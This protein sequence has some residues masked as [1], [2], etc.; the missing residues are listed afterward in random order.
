MKT[1]IHK[2]F[3]LFL[4]VLLTLLVTACSPN[5]DEGQETSITP[6][7]QGDND[8]Q[9]DDDDGNEQGSIEFSGEISSINGTVIV[10][11]G[12][13]VETASASLTGVLVQGATVRVQGTLQPNAV[14]VAVVIIVI[15]DV[16]VTPETTPPAE[17]TAETTPP[18]EATPESTPIVVDDD[19]I[20]IVI[21]GPVEA[22]NINIITIYGVNIV[23]SPNDPLLTV[24]QIGDVIRIEGAM[25]H[26]DDGLTIV[27]IAI[28][29][30][31]VDV[32]VFVLDGDVWRDEGNCGNP[33]PP[34]APANGWRRRC[35][36]GGGSGGGGGRGGSGR[37]GSG[38]GR[39]GSS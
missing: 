39:G 17:A 27:I 36:G 2:L 24:I 5:D 13:N 30:I 4:A 20:I 34:W 28:T 16:E 1:A 29:I 21:E 19:A 33:P 35:E 38:R 26:D 10:V 3:I 9:G 37:G 15:V 22:I 31:F 7:A 23:L 25:D 11:N 14:I 8:E 32:D 12:L 6:A 18:A